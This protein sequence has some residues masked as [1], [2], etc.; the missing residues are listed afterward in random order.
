MSI[1]YKISMW[2]APKIIEVKV[3]SETPMTVMVREEWWAA[4]RDKRHNK[5]GEYFP[6]FDEARD[7]LVQNFERD[8]TH[9]KDKVH[10]LQSYLGQA[11]SLKP[12]VTR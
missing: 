5:A 2:G 12:L 1:W 4:A 10:Q 9:A 7:C 3:I 6:T 11:R 8:L